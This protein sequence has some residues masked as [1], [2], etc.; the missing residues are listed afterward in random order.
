MPF[1]SGVKPESYRGA[2]A[3]RSTQEIV[4]G[5]ARVQ[6]PRRHRLV[7][8]D[9]VAADDDLVGELAF[10]RLAHEDPASRCRGN[11][12]GFHVY[13]ALGPRGE[14]LTGVE[15]V[16]AARQKMV[17]GVERDET[18]RVLRAVNIFAASSMSTTASR[19]N[20]SP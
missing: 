8:A 18:L 12:V 5:Q 14:Q 11:L 1:M 16:F 7:R 10:T 3:Q 20:A 19:A 17:G 2:S 15:R 13:I 9:H 6:A 4:G